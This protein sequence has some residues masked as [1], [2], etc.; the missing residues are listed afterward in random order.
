M[1][2]G[3]LNTSRTGPGTDMNISNNDLS[4]KSRSVLMRLVA[5]M[6]LRDIINT[7][8]DQNTRHHQHLRTGVLKI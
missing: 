7:E 6:N 4:T 2:R 5:N 3:Y 1:D 8:E